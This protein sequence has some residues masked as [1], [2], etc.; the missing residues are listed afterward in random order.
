MKVVIIMWHT[1]ALWGTAVS[2]S[3]DWSFTGQVHSYTGNGGTWYLRVI[4]CTVLTVVWGWP[5]WLTT[6]VSYTILQTL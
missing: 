2:G 1:W 4:T 6:S 3:C 5:E